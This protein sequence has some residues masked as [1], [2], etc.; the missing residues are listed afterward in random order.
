MILCTNLIRPFM[1]V[2]TCSIRMYMGNY[3]REPQTLLW[4]LKL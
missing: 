2:H 1:H 3:F 4:N